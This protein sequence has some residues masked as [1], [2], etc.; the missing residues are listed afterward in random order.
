M[1]E[2]DTLQPECPFCDSTEGEWM[3]SAPSFSMRGDRFMT[4]KKDAGFK[5]V[6][7]KIGERN[8]RTPV[9]EQL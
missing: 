7:S 8:P 6:L 3:L 1:S 9:N 4:T 2:K 5:E